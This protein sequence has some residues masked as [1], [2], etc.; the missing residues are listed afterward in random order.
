MI[1]I[2]RYT[3]YV[4]APPREKKLPRPSLAGSAFHEDLHHPAIGGCHRQLD[5][6][7]R[8]FETEIWLVQKG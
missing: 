1:S 8:D 4:P 6:I 7:S 2:G 3:Q 5:F